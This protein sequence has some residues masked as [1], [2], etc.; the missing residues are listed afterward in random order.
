[1]L[2]GV[3]TASLQRERKRR[4]IQLLR[5]A[6]GLLNG[7]INLSE[8]EVGSLRR[9]QERAHVPG[10]PRVVVR[11]PTSLVLPLEAAAMNTEGAPSAHVLD[12]SRPSIRTPPAAAGKKGSRKP[13]ADENE[14]HTS[15]ARRSSARRAARRDASARNTAARASAAAIPDLCL[16]DVELPAGEEEDALVDAAEA[17]TAPH[18]KAQ[19]RQALRARWPEWLRGIRSGSAL[20]LEGTGSKMRLLDDFASW[21]A[22]QEGAID[23][24][25]GCSFRRE[26]LEVDQGGAPQASA[27]ACLVVRGF[28]PGCDLRTGLSAAARRLSEEHRGLAERALA[29]VGTMHTMSADRAAR[30]MLGVLDAAAADQGGMIVS[31]AATSLAGGTAGGLDLAMGATGLAILEREAIASAMVDAVA[32]ETTPFLDGETTHAPSLAW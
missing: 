31:T 9:L 17:A 16:D 29:A 6:T 2:S 23:T 12:S 25:P 3:S 32:G 11:E 27:P 26:D 4:R 22:V 1:M 21:V 20:L 14:A 19:L 30:A 13:R 24:P 8:T 7:T 10:A 15:A 18:G 5:V 28:L